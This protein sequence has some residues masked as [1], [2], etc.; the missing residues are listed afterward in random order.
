MRSHLSFANVVSA[1]A[2]FVALGGSAFA[3][4]LARDSVKSKQ[5]KTGSVKLAELALNSV[6]SA[7]IIDGTING[8]DIADGAVGTADIADGAV[9]TAKLGANAVD[10]SKVAPDSLTGADI[11]EGSLSLPEGSVGPETLAVQPHVEA[12][13]TATQAVTPDGPIVLN[14]LVKSS[15]FTLDSGGALTAQVPGLYLVSADIRAN[16]NDWGVDFSNSEPTVFRKEPE[17]LT[18]LVRLEAGTTITMRNGEA[19]GF[20]LNAGSAANPPAQLIL[21]RVGS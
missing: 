20:T 18:K 15:G 2:L 19:V 9:G 16:A 21:V 6:D 8:G 11:T 7:R 3:V 4:G 5:I 13:R 1:V 17:T 10:G 14:N 12:T